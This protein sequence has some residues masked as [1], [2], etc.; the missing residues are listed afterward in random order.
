MLYRDFEKGQSFEPGMLHILE[1]VRFNPGE[2][3][4]SDEL[5]VKYAS[6]QAP[7][8][9]YFQKFENVSLSHP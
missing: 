5:S 1:N 8:Y 3:K 6:I 7:H 4:C 2:K 9:Q